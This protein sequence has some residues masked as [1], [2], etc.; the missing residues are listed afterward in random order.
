MQV[1]GPGARSGF[2]LAEVAVTIVIV[3]I[4]LVLVLQGLN[5]AKMTAAQT[6][7]LKL[8]RELGMLTLGQVECGI[9]QDDLDTGLAGNYAD[10]GYPDFTWEIAVGDDTFR[11]VGADG[12]FD[13]WAPTPSEQE[14]ES[15]ETEEEED[16]QEPYERVKVR[17]TFPVLG[18]FPSELVLE[19]WVRWEQAYGVAEAEDGGRASSNPRAV[20]PAEAAPGAE[21][22]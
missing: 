10:E 12:A 3:G 22:S 20:Q 17:V 1:R 18:D 15:E 16:A 7:N 11:E 9:L 6:R 13:S 8:A 14:A 4:A 2:T 21:G 5:T 19:R